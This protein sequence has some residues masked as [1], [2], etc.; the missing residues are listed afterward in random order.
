MS[1]LCTRGRVAVIAAL[2]CGLSTVGVIGVA[3]GPASAAA[4]INVPGDQPTIQA[5]INAAS[6]GDTVVVAPGTYLEHINFNGKAIEVKSSAGPASTIIDG[7]STGAVVTMNS[8][9]TASS[10]LRGF[11]VQHGGDSGIQL[12]SVA[13]VVTGNNIV[14]NHGTGNGGGI[15]V[16]FGAPQVTDNTIT[17][18][19][20]S[21]VNL[22]G[23]AGVVQGNTVQHNS[24]GVEADTESG[25]LRSLGT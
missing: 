3:A 4:T 12:I 14:N 10:I 1:S 24:L 16:Q 2:I 6:S 25:P 22:Y 7:S 19:F 17:D 13:A 21:G 18:N 5:G 11:T 9:E 15:S 23:S 20:G 8:S